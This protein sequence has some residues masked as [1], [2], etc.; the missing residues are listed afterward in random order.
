MVTPISYFLDLFSP[1][2]YEAFGRSD[3]AISG[4]R[5]RHKNAASRIRRGDKLVCYMTKLSRW[6]GVLEVL[7][8]PFE[9]STPIFFPESDPFALRFRVRPVIWLPVEKAV[10]IFEDNVWKHLSFTRGHARGSSHWTGKLRQSLV[11]LAAEDGQLIESLLTKQADGGA[12]YPV[13][14][15]EFRKLATHR[16]RRVDKD[17]NVTVPE[18]TD[19]D[20]ASKPL[21]TEVRESIRIQTVLA[22]IGDRMGMDI[23]VPRSDR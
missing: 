10:P 19:E 20:A 14:E 17:V 2:T 5:P 13:A 12:T 9:D 3:R 7:D 16:V 4:F 23:W 1:E 18:D 11:P 22:S 6:V 8:G 21:H 15:G